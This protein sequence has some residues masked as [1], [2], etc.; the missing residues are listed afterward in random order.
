[1]YPCSGWLLTLTADASPRPLRWVPLNTFMPG[2]DSSAETTQQML[3]SQWVDSSWLSSLIRLV[4]AGRV[5]FPAMQL[6][7]P[8]L[9]GR[10]SSNGMSRLGPQVSVKSSA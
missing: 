4:G 2:G 9:L 5:A 6:P 1:V 7:I 3:I 10:S 8:A